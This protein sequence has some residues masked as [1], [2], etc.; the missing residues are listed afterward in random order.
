MRRE[1]NLVIA[2]RPHTPKHISGGWSRYTDTSEPVD[3]NGAQNMV[4]VQSGF[5]TKEL[6]ITGPTRLPS[7]LIITGPTGGGIEEDEAVWETGDSLMTGH[8]YLLCC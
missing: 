3:G 2:V 5:R 6:S 8:C 4:I 1:L 7:A